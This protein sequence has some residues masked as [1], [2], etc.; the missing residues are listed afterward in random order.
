MVR[1]EAP[2][3]FEAMFRLRVAQPGRGVVF[4]GL[5]GRRDQGKI[6]G[7]PFCMHGTRTSPGRLGGECRY[8]WGTTES[9]VWQGLD[10]R[11]ALAAG[12]AT[13]SLI[14]DRETTPANSAERHVDVVV[15]TRNTTD[16][17]T[18]RVHGGARGCARGQTDNTIDK[19][20]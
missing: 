16:L 13:V 9:H 14:V 7:F 5:Y 15:L 1:F 20:D 19:H 4:E 10:N 8:A 11:V 18:R 6:W 17:E 3:R 2:Y 12:P